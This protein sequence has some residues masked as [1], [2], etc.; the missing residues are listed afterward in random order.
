MED[1][2]VE[3]P[4][5]KLQ[6]PEKLQAASSKERLSKCPGERRLQAAAAPQVKLL[7]RTRSVPILPQVPEG[8]NSKW[9]GRGGD[10]EIGIWNFSGAW[11]LEPGA[12]QK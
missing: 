8:T 3:A 2:V 10:L 5:S 7:A 6:P 9:R 11:M 4:N 12:F 1:N